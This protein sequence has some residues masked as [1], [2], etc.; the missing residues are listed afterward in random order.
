MTELT[1]QEQFDKPEMQALLTDAEST[2]TLPLMYVDKIRW[3]VFKPTSDDWHP[4]WPGNLVKVSFLTLDTPSAGRT[5]WSVCV[6]GHD[7]YGMERDLTSEEEAFELFLWVTN[8][9]DVTQEALSGKGFVIAKE[10][11]KSRLGED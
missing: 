6:W 5:T 1:K 3:D 10:V 4:N 11:E 8:L 2:T 9:A 7:N